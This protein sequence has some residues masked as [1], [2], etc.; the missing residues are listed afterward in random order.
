MAKFINRQ[1][2]SIIN[3][4]F[5]VVIIVFVAFL[6]RLILNKIEQNKIT[7]IF[8]IDKDISQ[9][10]EAMYY[11]QLEGTQV[12]CEL[13]P[14]KCLLNNGQKGLCRVKQNINGR[15]YSL[16][17]SKPV[18]IHVDPIEKKPLFHFLPGSNVYSLATVGC[19]LSCQHCQNWDISQT[20]PEEAKTLEMTPEQVVND[21][22][23]QNTSI[24]AFT[25]S[26]PVVFY[27]Y[28]IDIAKLA[29]EKNLKTIIISNGYIN[30]EPLLNLLPYLDAVKIDLKAF[31]EKFYEKI[32]NGRLGPV[33]ENIKT[34]KESGKHIEIVYLIIPGENDSEEEIKNMSQWLKDNIGEDTIIHFSRFYPQYKMANKQPTPIE[35]IKKAREI[36]LKV[37][38]KYVY[39]GNIEYPI[40]ET[41]YC[42]DGTIAIRRQGY[43]ILNN[44]LKNGRCSDNTVIPGV[45]Q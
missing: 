27:E 42:D 36:A 38:L 29:H 4:I 33:L 5:V 1:K 20:N 40:G 34:V 37:G 9:L 17:Y 21:A 24:I 15:L 14:N 44:K 35:I 41:T 30:K 25:Y 16:V 23:K 31:S 45:W 7:N 22:I 10:K 13:C 11:K 6:P 18:T 3:V 12:Q 8:S 32:T 19:N 43:F 39:T 26:E 28:V 2:I